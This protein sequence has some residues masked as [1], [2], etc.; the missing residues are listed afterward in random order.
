ML[1]SKTILQKRVA[2]GAREGDINDAIGVQ[3]PHFRFP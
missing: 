3:V 2:N 1:L